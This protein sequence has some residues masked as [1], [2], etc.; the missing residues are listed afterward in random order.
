[1]KVFLSYV[2]YL[3]SFILTVNLVDIENHKKETFVFFM[4]LLSFIITWKICKD[5]IKKT[6]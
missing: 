3:V 2:V 4:L 1:M 6:F 5:E